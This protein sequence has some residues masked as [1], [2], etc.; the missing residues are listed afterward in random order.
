MVS[1]S[2]QTGYKWKI[3]A[4]DIKEMKPINKVNFFK[5]DIFDQ[6]TKGILDFFNDKL[7]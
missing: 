2:R 3:L 6:S 1:S 7:M 4:I 5:C